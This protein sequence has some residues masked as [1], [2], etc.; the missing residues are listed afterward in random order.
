MTRLAAILI[1]GPP[2]TGKS[3][4]AEALAPRLG[5]AL[6]DLDVATAPLTRVISGLTGVHDLDDPALARPT[7]AARYETL[8]GLA[9][10]NLRTGRP[11]VLVAPPEAC[12]RWQSRAESIYAIDGTAF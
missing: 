5:A 4:L 3:T 10:A 6:L 7:R 1:G 2:A 8:I 11:V 12:H 9:A